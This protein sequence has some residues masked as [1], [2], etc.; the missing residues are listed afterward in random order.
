[1][2]KIL[3]LLSSYNGEK[4]ITAQIESIMN[5]KVDAIVNL[6][7]RDDGSKD[8]TC[9]II[10]E[11]KKI[12]N[13]RIE[14]IEGKNIGYNASFFD[15]LRNAQGYDYY[16]ISDQDDIW[17]EDKLKKAI[18]MLEEKDDIPLLYASKSYLVHDDMVPYG[19][20]R[21][22]KRDITIYNSLIQNICP[23]HTQVMN[24]KMLQ[25]LKKEI[26]ISKVY[27]YDSWIENMACLY[28]EIVYDNTSHTYY[29]QHNMNVM[30]TSESRIRKIKNCIKRVCAGEDKKYKKQIEYFWELNKNELIK[31]GFYT[32]IK[33]F[34]EI[35]KIASRLVFVIKGK[36]YRQSRMETYLF[37]IS[38]LFGRY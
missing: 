24:N 3:V 31:K 8:S 23:G 17:M 30:G 28:G 33:K 10:K 34:V 14:L 19:E 35:N 29:R 6:R 36:F 27:V 16:S 13:D 2:K 4:Y 1:M 9:K 12:Y 26:D 20:T 7:I 37:Y 32:E 38:V 18:E 22:K 5:Q 15:L 11:M 25:K 21:E